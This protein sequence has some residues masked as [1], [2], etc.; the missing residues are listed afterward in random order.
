[1]CVVNVDSQALV[2]VGRGDGIGADSH[3]LGSGEPRNRLV[4]G[5]VV[6]E[7]GT[8]RFD[9]DEHVAVLIAVAVAG[10]RCRAGTCDDVGGVRHGQGWWPVRI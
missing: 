5:G 7:R 1:M 9:H 3:A 6:D 8:V 10:E 2:A 4:A